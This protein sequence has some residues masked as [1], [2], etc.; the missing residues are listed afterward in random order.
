MKTDPEN[1][2]EVFSARPKA[3]KFGRAL[4]NLSSLLAIFGGFV[5]LLI[6]FINVFSITGRV[7]FSSPL[8][9]DFELVEMGCAI[10]IF[11]F[12]PLCHLKKGNVIVDF[13]T[14]GL[15]KGIHQILD[16]LSS[17]LYAIVALFFSWRM[18]Y[19]AADMLHY[20]EQTMLLKLPVWIAFI[21]GVV[22]FLLLSVVC[23]Y[24]FIISIERSEVKS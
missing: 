3:T 9:G 6:V 7:L 20:N 13:F 23:F 16:A 10:A 5:L 11:S 24:T 2:N 21:P 22:S 14:L 15:D 4:L 18:I 19:G 17:F 1:K 12:L 8:M